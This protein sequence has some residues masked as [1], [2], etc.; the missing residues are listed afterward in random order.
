MNSALNTV[1]PAGRQITRNVFVDGITVCRNK[2]T[3]RP[4][5]K[6]G[7]PQ[8]HVNVLLPLEVLGSYWSNWNEPDIIKFKALN[9]NTYIIEDDN[10]LKD[11][12]KFMEI[13]GFR[14]SAPY[15]HLEGE[16]EWEC[17]PSPSNEHLIEFLR[18][19]N[20]NYDIYT[21][22]GT[23][24]REANNEKRKFNLNVSHQ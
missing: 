7:K 24:I 16:H 20:Y 18:A 10:L 15:I 21:C 3:H 12:C 2:K 4:C 14:N 9:G 19:Y 23:L 17:Y 6:K 13:N 5:I 22:D 11:V 1:L 8:F